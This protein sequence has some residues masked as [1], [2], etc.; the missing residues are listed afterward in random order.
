MK[1]H[2][3]WDSL[4]GDKG[5]AEDAIVAAAA[6]PAADPSLAT[7]SEPKTWFEEGAQLAQQVVYTDAIGDGTGPFTIDNAYFETATRVARERAALAGARL[8]NLLN[9]ALSQQAKV[10]EPAAAPKHM[11]RPRRNLSSMTQ[12]NAIGRAST[13]LVVFASVPPAGATITAGFKFDVPVRFNIDY[14]EIDYTTWRAGQI[15]DIPVIEIRV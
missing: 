6:L 4:L 7:V 8:A 1:L 9:V 11:R 12:V 5:R 13:G 15:P 14:L 10:R 3:F 2:A